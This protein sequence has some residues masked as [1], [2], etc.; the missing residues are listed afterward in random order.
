MKWLLINLLLLCSLYGEEVP[1][2]RSVEIDLKVPEISNELPGPGKR[3]KLKLSKYEQ[4]NLFHILYLPKNWEKGKKY[5]VIVEYAG[6]G[7][8]KNTFG[9]TSTGEVEGSVLGYGLTEGKD[10]IWLCLPYVNKEKQANQNQWWGDVNATVSYCLNAVNEVC[11]NYGGDKENLILCGFSRGSIACNF[12]GLHNDEISKLWKAFFCYSHYDGVRKWNYPESDRKSALTRL[13]RLG[14]RPQFIIHEQSVQETKKYLIDVYP[15]GNFTFVDLK[16]RNHNP[17]WV[18]RP[19]EERKKAQAWLH[20][21][22]LR[23]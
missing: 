23:K 4:T 5:P 20:S 6:N 19:T 21:I 1:D 2:I 11:Q 7:P 15:K 9:D 3:V 22:I 14:N 16:Y 10:F 17:T 18:L 8:Y 12:I 13:N